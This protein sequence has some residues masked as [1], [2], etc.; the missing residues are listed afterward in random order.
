MTDH[1]AWRGNPE[2]SRIPGY[3]VWLGN[4]R[5]NRYSHGH[6]SLD[7]A[8]DKA[9]YWDYDWHEAGLYD[10][11]AEIEFILDYTGRTQVRHK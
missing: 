6:V 5:G 7:P 10:V 8:V 9:E 1:P 11:P 3:D 4:T 2:S